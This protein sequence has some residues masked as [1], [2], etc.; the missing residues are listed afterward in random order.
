[1]TKILIEL[2]TWLGDAI[3]TTPAIENIVNHLNE[4]EISLLGSA[5]SIGALRNHPKVIKTYKH[6]KE[7]IFYYKTLKELDEYDIFISFRNSL[8]A[9][10]A[11]LLISAKKK[12]Q[13]DKH[14]FKNNHQVQRYNDFINDCLDINLVPKNLI[15]HNNINKIKKKKKLLG[16]NPGASY[17]SAKRWYPKKFAEVGYALSSEFD[18]IIFGGPREIDIADDIEHNLIKYGVNNYQNLASKTSISELILQVANL[19]LFITG[20]S[21]PMHIAAAFEVPTVT[22]FGPT[23]YLE[24]SQWMN[25]K[26]IIVKKNLLC[27]PCMKRK[28][29]LKHHNCMKMVEAAEVLE[30][31]DSF[32]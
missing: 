27:Q 15:L 26:S 1:M 11:K 2:P 10:L 29:P 31:V 14:K 9:K 24:T 25:S 18:I 12:Y 3:M 7:F 4:V 32:I 6:D 17:G 8:R 5:I 28:C 21:G 22:I 19:D 23:N 13:F 30:A 16:I 20:D